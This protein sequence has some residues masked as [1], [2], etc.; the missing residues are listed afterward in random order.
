MANSAQASE[1]H[2][3]FLSAYAPKNLT[4]IIDKLAGGKENLKVSIKEL[5]FTIRKEKYNINGEIIFN[6]IHKPPLPQ[7]TGVEKDGKD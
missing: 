3:Q 1:L 2:E 4:E 6:I 7:K 5:K